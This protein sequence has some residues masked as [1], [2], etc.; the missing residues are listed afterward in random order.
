VI[1]RVTICEPQLGLNFIIIDLF[2][3][4]MCRLHDLWILHIVGVGIVDA[5]EVIAT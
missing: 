3:S 2:P 1:F 5:V 4:G